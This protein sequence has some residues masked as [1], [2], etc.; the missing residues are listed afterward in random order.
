[1]TAGKPIQIPPYYLSRKWK[2]SEGLSLHERLQDRIDEISR[3]V[4]TMTLKEKQDL[5][6]KEPYYEISKIIVASKDFIFPNK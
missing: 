5:W 1:M 6:E 2:N 4:N 3:K